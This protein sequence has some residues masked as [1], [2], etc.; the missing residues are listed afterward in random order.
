M[1]FIDYF[2]NFALFC[3]YNEGVKFLT[4]NLTLNLTKPL[5]LNEKI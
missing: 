5:Y 3:T 4:A 2:T 1:T